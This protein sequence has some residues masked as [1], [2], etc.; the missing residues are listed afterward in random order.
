MKKQPVFFLSHGGGPC[1]WIEMPPP[2]GPHGFDDLRG[3]FEGLLASLPERPKAFVVISGHWETQSFTVSTNPAPGMLFDYSGFP[4]HTYELCYPAK[5]DPVIANRITGLLAKA[6]ISHETDA[7]R[8]FDHGVFVP[9]LIVDPDGEIPVVMISIRKDFDPAAHIALGE[10][11]APL[12]DEGVVIVGSGNSYHNMMSFRD[13]E[14]RN[15]QVFDRWLQDAVTQRDFAARKA[16][17]LQ[18]EQAPMARDAQPREDHLIPLMTVI[19]AGGSDPAIA[20]FQGTMGGK[21]ISGFRI[22]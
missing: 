15:S 3:Y 22:G 12:R 5:G 4:P 18:W 7:V 6:D 2:F 17:L 11:L 14:T 8:G 10:A 20:D 13:G 21:A 16:A 9:M 1:F 19:G